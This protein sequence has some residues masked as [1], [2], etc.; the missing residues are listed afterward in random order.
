MDSK[1][2]PYARMSFIRSPGPR[3]SAAVAID[4]SE[5]YRVGDM[6]S[7]AFERRA[8]KFPLQNSIQN[9]FF[10]DFSVFLG[11]YH[12]TFRVSLSTPFG[13][14]SRFYSVNCHVK[15]GSLFCVRSSREGTRYPRR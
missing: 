3:P 14:L 13:E 8:G 15:P 10:I 9:A 7:T 5:K 6:R 2:Q 1:N 11:T 12:T 4:G